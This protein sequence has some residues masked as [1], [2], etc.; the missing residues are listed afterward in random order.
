MMITSVKEHLHMTADKLHH[1]FQVSL[2]LHLQLP[3][4][5]H[6]QS[7]DIP[8]TT[9]EEFIA[10]TNSSAVRADFP[11]C[12][13]HSSGSR[14]CSHA[15]FCLRL[16]CITFSI[17]NN[18]SLRFPPCWFSGL[19]ATQIVGDGDLHCALEKDF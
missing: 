1:I 13:S 12:H 7:E 6:S 8:E 4:P 5:I 19:N 14:V 16:H 9:Q 10:L 18:I 2:T 11:Q 17:S 15:L 3:E